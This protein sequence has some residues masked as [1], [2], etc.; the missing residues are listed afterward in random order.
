MKDYTFEAQEIDGKN[1]VILCLQDFPDVK[2]RFKSIR[3]GSKDD[4]NNIP[5]M[6]E[7]DLIGENQN[8]PEDPEFS[9]QAAQILVD[10][11]VKLSNQKY[12]IVNSIN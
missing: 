9:N 10:L 8:F 5:I 1:E 11:L 12:E 7:I 6:F 4:E 2:F 3:V